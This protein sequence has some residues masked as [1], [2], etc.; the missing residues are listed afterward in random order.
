MVLTAWTVVAAT[1]ASSLCAR[2]SAGGGDVADVIVATANDA[3]GT[4]SGGL[5]RAYDAS[6][7]STAESCAHRFGP[8][9]V[10]A[11][12]GVDVAGAAAAIATGPGA[13]YDA[14][15]GW[16]ENAVRTMASAAEDLAQD[17]VK[18]A[19]MIIAFFK[20]LDCKLDG[21]F[22]KQLASALQMPGIDGLPEIVR[23][24]LGVVGNGALDGNM[25]KTLWNTMFGGE[26]NA[27][28]AAD[29]LRGA[30]QALKDNCPAVASG[31][32]MP[33]FTFGVVLEGEVSAGAARGAGLEVG[34]G[35]DF[36]GD[37]FCFLAHCAWAGITLDTPSGSVAAGF[38]VTGYKSIASVPGTASFLSL[39]IGLGNPPFPVDGDGGI[40][41][42]YSGNKMDET[43]GVGF[44]LSGSRDAGGI[45]PATVSVAKGVCDCPVCVTIDGRKCGEVEPALDTTKREFTVLGGDRGGGDFHVI[46]DISEHAC[47][48]ECVKY[49]YCVGVSYSPSER[50]CVLKGTDGLEQTAASSYK[51]HPRIPVGFM[52]QSDGDRPGGDIFVLKEVSIED[53]AQRCL[54]W[55][56]CV[57][58]SYRS[59]ER[60]CVLKAE[61]GLEGSYH[62]NN[63]QY[64]HRI[65]SPKSLFANSGL[66]MDGKDRAGGTRAQIGTTLADCKA[67]CVEDAGCIGVSY[68]STEG[69]KGVPCYTKGTN[70]VDM[71]NSQNGFQFI[72]RLPNG[73]RVKQYG[74]RGGGDLFAAIVPLTQCAELCFARAD[75]IGFSFNSNERRCV[76]KGGNANTNYNHGVYQFYERVESAPT[77]Y[78]LAPDRGGGDIGGWMHNT[79]PQ[80]CFAECQKNPKCF[81]VTYNS[82]SCV[83]KGT[84]AQAW[85]TPNQW[86]FAYKVPK[87]FAIRGAGDR[88]GGDLRVMYG[89]IEACARACKEEP[90][91]AGV[92]HDSLTLRCTLKRLDGLDQHHRVSAQQ[93][94]TFEPSTALEASATALG[95]TLPST[96]TT[97]RTNAR[98]VVVAVACAFAVA[99]ATT[100]RRARVARRAET[101]GSTY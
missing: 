16:S 77:H 79:N 28:K 12:G 7:A 47:T 57:G 67:K 14:A 101:Y 34:F 100:L 95:E 89:Q 37:V 40:T 53:C 69:S 66:D 13:Q 76:A 65:A 93:F 64:Y 48:T 42:V 60:R 98:I 96:A 82:N 25:C 10:D 58:F 90:Q 62:I 54:A 61:H 19:E 17:A 31:G 97:A 32:D 24:G 43:V 52:V 35:A 9:A 80:A 87:D 21:N 30:T 50:R 26:A 27:K 36:H 71:H 8:A 78:V 99:A 23:G 2:V 72:H 55:S 84:N 38:Q 73:F 94:Y 88:P 4:V 20:G 33:A 75:C 51:F 18:L 74:D 91:C 85:Y 83:L 39:G 70:G 11:L 45:M 29:A 46:T 3:A 63:H 49:S 81:G 1:C 68:R 59:H 41:F 56:N 22:F 86:H 44:T 92:S 15:L 6:I 5:R